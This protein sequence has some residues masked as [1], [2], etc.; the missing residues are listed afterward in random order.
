[1]FIYRGRARGRIR[2]RLRGRVG[3]GHRQRSFE[4][5][6]VKLSQLKAEKIAHVRTK[7]SS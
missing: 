4:G 5:R 3:K 7:I 1:M 6:G 2:G